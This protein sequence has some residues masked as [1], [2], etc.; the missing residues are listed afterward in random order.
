M[1]DDME[2]WP[3]IVFI[4][5][6]YKLLKRNF[7][8]M[9]LLVED[10]MGLSKVVGV[11]LLAQE[12]RPTF[13]WFLNCFKKEHQTAWTKMQCM[14]GDKD[15]NERDVLKEVFPNI[16]IY[17]CLFHT[18]RT[19]GREIS[20]EKMD[21]SSEE[22]TKSLHFLNT[23]AKS[24]SQQHYDTTYEKFSNEVPGAVLNYF[25]KNWHPIAHEWTKFS[26]NC[27]NLGNLTNNR[28]ESINSKIKQMVKKHSTMVAFVH[29]FFKW[30]T[31]REHEM[32]NKVSKNFVKKKVTDHE[33]GSAELQYMKELTTFAFSIVEQEIA[34]HRAITFRRVDKNLKT[35]VIMLHNVK[36]T[37]TPRTCECATWKSKF[38]PCRH[39]FATRKLFNLPLFAE[40][41]YSE[42]WK[43]GS[44][45]ETNP[46]V[47]DKAESTKGAGPEVHNVSVTQ[48][49]SQK[50]L[51]DAQKRKKLTMLANDIV[52]M[53]MLSTASNF[54]IR[55][56][57][58]VEIRN[59][60]RQGDEVSIT[61][62]SQANHTIVELE[63][64]LQDLRMDSESNS[65]PKTT[66][67]LD[68]LVLPVPLKRRNRSRYTD[69][70]TVKSIKKKKN[71]LSVFHTKR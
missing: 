57:N 27:G 44:I 46:L 28:L 7:T 16:P 41:L 17:I 53:G 52:Q 31:N 40:E 21:I 36:I 38:L 49:S 47:R 33:S 4:D 61:T 14:M 32:L 20:R 71:Y 67:N 70:T 22:R 45:L 58:L 29:S 10:S 23:L 12:D 39:M 50:Q 6:T 65:V 66:D 64:D 9:I 34:H 30:L 48:C 55:V 1:R 25:N 51:S 56:D 8:V 19:F 59:A 54:S 63:Q 69:M 43:K 37:A 24:T 5:D 42:R 62:G 15:L 18:L 3:E 68:D 11:A 35:C 13:Q 60:W 26:M 2:P